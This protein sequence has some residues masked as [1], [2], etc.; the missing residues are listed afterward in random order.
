MLS[1][2]ILSIIFIIVSGNLYSKY[3]KEN[4]NYTTFLKNNLVLFLFLFINMLCLVYELN[5]RH[6][7]KTNLL[8]D[9]RVNLD[10]HIS[11]P[12]IN[13]VYQPYIDPRAMYM[14]VI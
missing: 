7:L 8:F 11:R 5:K 12:N 6:F 3:K 1:I 13:K 10:N 9:N 4:I 2:I 14:D